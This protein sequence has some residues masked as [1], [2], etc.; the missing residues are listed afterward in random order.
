MEMIAANFP[1]FESFS[2]ADMRRIFGVSKLNEALN[3]HSDTFASMMF[4]N[5]GDGTFSVRPLPNEAQVSP[6]KSIIIHDVDG[7]GISEIII[8]GNIYHT[9]PN[10]A[11]ADAGNGLLLKS[12][13]DGT[14]TPIPVLKSGLII[15]GDLRTLTLINTPD[16]FALVAGNNNGNVQYFR[17]QH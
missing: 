4:E 2:T 17:I 9:E 15:P 16:G 14:L 3:L 12:N 7:N 1:S 6:V 5:H 10:I 13:G 11:R 8:A